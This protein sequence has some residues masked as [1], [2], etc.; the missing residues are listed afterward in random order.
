MSNKLKCPL[1]KED[2]KKLIENVYNTC[3]E[4]S[5]SP[6]Y[7]S[8]EEFNSQTDTLYRWATYLKNLLNLYSNIERAESLGLELNKLRAGGFLNEE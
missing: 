8:E 4:D 2:C 6:G 3:E 1:T 7:L 5:T